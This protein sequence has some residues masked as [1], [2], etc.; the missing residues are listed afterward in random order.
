MAGNHAESKATT[1]ATSKALAEKA[2][3]ARR[4]S[5][6]LVKEIQGL[7][8]VLADGDPGPRTGRQGVAAPKIGPQNADAEW[9][10]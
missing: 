2:E 10:T 7:A 3:E 9:A 4:L 6:Q 8:Q 1:E 5:Q